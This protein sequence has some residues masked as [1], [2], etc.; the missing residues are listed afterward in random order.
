MVHGPAGLLGDHGPAQADAA[1]QEAGIDEEV[2]SNSQCV[3][4]FI[5]G[6]KWCWTP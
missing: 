5:P 6:G 4:Y 2:L 1:Q 3:A